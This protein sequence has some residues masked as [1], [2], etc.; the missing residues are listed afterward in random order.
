[1]TYFDVIP[2]NEKDREMTN[3]NLEKHSNL[4]NSSPNN[5][6]ELLDELEQELKFLKK[7]P[8]VPDKL[9][10]KMPKMH[11]TKPSPLLIELERQ[12]QT[13]FNEIYNLDQ[14]SDQVQQ[15]Y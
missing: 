11:S 14:S 7:E 4:S 9:K 3:N 1:M 5:Q 10:P 2:P 12:V 13:L 15:S 6:P 8:K